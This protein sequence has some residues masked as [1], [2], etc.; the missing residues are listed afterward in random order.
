MTINVSRYSWYACICVVPTLFHCRPGMICSHLISTNARIPHATYV[1]YTSGHVVSVFVL[2]SDEVIIC[3]SYKNLVA[4]G[5]WSMLYAKKKKVLSWL[6]WSC[7]CIRLDWGEMFQ[8]SVQIRAWLFHTMACLSAT[9]WLN[10][11]CAWH[12]L[13]CYIQQQ[14]ETWHR[15]CV[16]NCARNFFLIVLVWAYPVLPCSPL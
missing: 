3:S 6:S 16:R 8:Y 13:L 11:R 10:D 7:T 1:I 15:P 9:C 12:P 2:V 5:V 14:S 4:T